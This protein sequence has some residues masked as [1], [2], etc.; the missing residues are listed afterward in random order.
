MVYTNEVPD[1]ESLA[2]QAGFDTINKSIAQTLTWD[3]TV[4]SA[5]QYVGV[6]VDSWTWGEDTVF[7][8]GDGGI[9]EI[10]MGVT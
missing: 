10:A 1:G 5:N 7:F 4:L 8:T 6:F 3:G 9:N 2:F